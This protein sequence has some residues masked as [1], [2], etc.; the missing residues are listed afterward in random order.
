MDKKDNLLD[1][2]LTLKESILAIENLNNHNWPEFNLEKFKTINE[3]KKEVFYKIVNE[4]K[5]TP[6]ILQVVKC[7][8]FNLKF[9]RVRELSTIKNIDVFSEH[10]YP[11]PYFTKM[12]RCN[13]PENP[14]FY[15]SNDPG[16]SLF[17]V[18]RDGNYKKKQF[19]ISKWEIIPSE[20]IFIFENY[21]RN[22]LPNK[23]P[24]KDLNDNLVERLD[25]TFEGKLTKEK[26]EGVFKYLEFIDNSF[27]N[28]NNYS[29]SASIAHDSLF[30]EHET[31]ADVL[32]YPSRQSNLVG[33]NLA[34]NPN[35]VNNNMKIS[36]FYTVEINNI[37]EKRDKYNIS[38]INYGKVINRLTYW[39]KIM[40]Q[41]EE[42]EKFVQEDFGQSFYENIDSNKK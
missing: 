28:D 17:E 36:R 18:I 12:G 25:E 27:I 35:F 19:C 20:E 1:Q 8:E 9:F 3:F 23:N 33:L 39:R 30:R 7:N 34:I 6:N 4:F 37:S 14:V 42:F 13:F 22:E 29:L 15:C 24:F 40:Q 16:T 5:F 32:M 26:R 38:F 41:D 2:I 11:P 10:S 21:L 31:R